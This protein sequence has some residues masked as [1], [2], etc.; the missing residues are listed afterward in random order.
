MSKAKTTRAARP[1]KDAASKNT[2]NPPAGGGPH[3]DQNPNGPQQHDMP[4]EI[5]QYGGAGEPPLMK[6]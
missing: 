2:F 6:K 1:H 3:G 5:G 4:R